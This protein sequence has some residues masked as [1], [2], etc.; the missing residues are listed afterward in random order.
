MGWLWT[1]KKTDDAHFSRS[2][3]PA[4]LTRVERTHTRVKP[5][6]KS[7]GEAAIE[8]RRLA[9]QSLMR[10]QIDAVQ[11]SEDGPISVNVL[12]RAL[13]NRF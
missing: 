4:Q 5:Q 13:P 6:I 7:P 8:T 1:S 12:Q 2:L 9:S 10:R 3:E 11:G